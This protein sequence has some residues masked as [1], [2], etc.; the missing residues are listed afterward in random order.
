[1]VVMVLKVLMVSVGSKC[2]NFSQV[3]DGFWM[4]LKVLMAQMFRRFCWSK[5]SKCSDGF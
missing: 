4:V 2:S 5:G 3:S 1:M